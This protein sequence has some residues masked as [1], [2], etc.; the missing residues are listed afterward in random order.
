M[1]PDCP[2]GGIFFCKYTR[3]G[4][5]TKKLIARLILFTLLLPFIVIGAPFVLLSSAISWVLFTAEWP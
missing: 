1:R 4:P 3:H 5:A 2:C